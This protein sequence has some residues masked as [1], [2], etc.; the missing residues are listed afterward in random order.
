MTDLPEDGE[1]G[2]QPAATPRDA[3]GH[4]CFY[5]HFAIMLIIVFGWIAP[6]KAALGFYVLFL[7]AVAIQWLFN[8]NSCI[9]NNLESLLRSGQWRD[10]SNE[11]EGA[12][13]L[14]L[15]RNTLGI[16]AT[17]AQM[18]VFIYVVLALLWAAGA[19]HFFGAF[20]WRPVP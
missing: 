11:E 9:L 18:D 13:L 2:D 3:L 17:Q 12:W 20:G 15:A 16:R 5:L 19:A 6:W 14:T 7:P 1:I 8:K 10:P 4:A